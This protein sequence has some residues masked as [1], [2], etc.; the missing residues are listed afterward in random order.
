MKKITLALLLT[1]MSFT[2][3]AGIIA[4]DVESYHR[5]DMDFMF[6]IK[7]KSYDKVVLDCQGFI[8]ALNLY[9]TRGHDIFTIPGYG[10]CMAIH[11][12]II[13]NIRV[14]KDSCVAI[15]DEVGEI[16]VLDSKCPQAK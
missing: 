1:L 9:S 16:L 6:I 13:K 10:Q 4:I 7:N 8:N 5:T 2:T 3:Q 12:E 14:K 11:N 15:N